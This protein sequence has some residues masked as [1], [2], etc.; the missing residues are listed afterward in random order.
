MTQTTYKH[1]TV[2]I[3][4][5]LATVLMDKA[6]SP[7]NSISPD[8][9]AELAE[10]IERVE[11]DTEIKA[12]V[13]GSAKRNNFL[14]GADIPWLFTLEDSSDA[15]ELLT[16]G[17]GLFQR[18]EDLHSK[19][20]KPVVAA[21]DGACLGGGCE[22]AL[23]SGIRI[24]TDNKKTVLGQP[25]VKI[26]VIPAGGG[27]Q[28]LPKLVGIT[29][30]LDLILTGK[31]IRPHKARKIGLV[32]EVCPS[33][34]LMAVA[35]KR[36]RAAIGFKAKGPSGL[37]RLKGLLSPQAIQQLALEET[38]V[39]RNL[40][41]SKAEEKLL[42]TTGGNYPAPVAALR[43]IRVGVEDG[44]EAGYAAEVAEFSK[45]VTSPEAKA[46]MSVFFASTELKKD[47]GIDSD[48]KPR[49]V[50]NV[51][52]LGAG[53]M[54]SGIT[55]VN[56]VKAGVRTRLK[57]VSDE[58]V[59]KGMAYV[60]RVLDKQVKRRWI[61]KGEADRAMFKITGTTDFSG[62]GKVDVVIEAVFEDLDLKRSMVA[63]IEA[64]TPDTTIFATNTSSIPITQI[65]EG[66]KRPGNIIGMHYFSPVEKM[67]LLE[68]I[69][70]D[71]TEDWV[72]ATCVALGKRQGL[73]VIVVRDGAGFYTT[74]VLAPYMNEVGHL[75]EEG[76]S[77]ESIDAAMVSWG[78]PVGP[79][80]LT[81]EVGIDVGAKIGK[82]MHA[83]FG[84][85]LKPVA[86]YETLVKDGR[87]GRKNGRGFY[88]YTDGKKGG[89]DESVYKVLG[90]PARIEMEVEEIQRRLGLLFI[91]EAARCLEEGILRSARDGDIGAI[92]GL[93]FPPFRGG[94]FAHIDHVG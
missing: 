74:R 32:D 31:N 26:G 79:I 46:L 24:A 22:L 92:F 61:T 82:I 2:T 27:T 34:V 80:T 75:L 94:P 71:A 77:I 63:E 18:I 28:R 72:T 35:A 15:L 16:A 85:R 83:A 7:V 55:T 40:L 44:S 87:Y 58:G 13:I 23:A 76:V 36:A 30:A 68:V 81:D 53:L 4:D 57:D 12:L 91:N 9:G 37:D 19:H 43:A 1:F 8:F 29:T 89:V 25:E 88:T 47:S 51:G 84:D 67:P 78:F 3:D 90:T 48:V 93:G 10:I 38:P 86:G 56:T 69:V 52:V 5:G 20:G 39:G 70:T 59:A 66:S 64:V 62:F 14:A 17:Q 11:T 42:A 65:A 73:T 54:G 49:E 21:I 33:E 41:F 45:L 6:D 50:A 60:R